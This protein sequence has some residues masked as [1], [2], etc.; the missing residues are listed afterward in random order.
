MKN[1]TSAKPSQHAYKAFTLI[2]LLV[3]IAIIAI[4]AAI[5]F[6]VFARARENARR[7]SCQSNLKQISLAMMQ[8]SQDYDER[9]CNYQVGGRSWDYL[10]SPYAGMKV[11]RESPTQ[12]SAG[13]FR[14]PSDTLSRPSSGKPTRSYAIPRTP[15]AEYVDAGRGGGPDDTRNFGQTEGNGHSIDTLGGRSVADFQAPST[16]LMIVECPYVDNTFG[17]VYNASCVGPISNDGP[18]TNNSRQDAA[19]PGVPNHFEGWNY[20]FVDG[21]VKWLRPRATMVGANGQQPGGVV[22]TGYQGMWTVNPND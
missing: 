9:Y 3:V 21:H 12:S 14:C 11:D 22:D 8:Y 16:T 2:E 20:A 10:I 17:E 15:W 5:L 4:L 6:P 18:G 7:A 13:V 19:R 1:H